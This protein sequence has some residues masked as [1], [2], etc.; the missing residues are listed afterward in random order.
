[1]TTATTASSSDSVLRAMT[2]DGAFR[3]L[4]TRATDTVKNML[5]AH[6]LRGQLA[7]H[8]A[9]LLVCATLVRETMAPTHRVQCILRSRDQRTRWVAD[10]HPDGGVRALVAQPKSEAGEP[11]SQTPSS[12]E[13]GTLE[14]VRT[15]YNGELHRGV[16][17]V[18][19]GGGVSEA[20]M[21][22]LQSSEQV[23]SML[24]IACVL[25]ADEVVAAGGYL[26]QLLP[27]V[28]VA[29]LAIMAERLRDFEHI[30]P[31]LA[32]HDAAT[33]PLLEE[34]LY[35]M[36]FTTLEERPLDWRCRCSAVRVMSTLATLPVADLKDLIAD[37]KPIELACD[38]CGQNY[39]VSPQ[40]LTGMLEQS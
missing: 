11:A 28:G 10:S 38:F 39:A 9:E 36:P 40:Q 7:E 31:F 26:V 25:D 18:P 8:L 35:G 30:G 16:V 1:M 6:R 15:L 5:L 27:E 32:K 24:S 21:T 4:T 23:A 34:L 13:G 29:P 14:V 20:L 3:V 37:G 12:I 2:D 22:Y 17:Q 33:H 19:S